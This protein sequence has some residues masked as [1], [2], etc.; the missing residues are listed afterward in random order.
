VNREPVLSADHG[1]DDPALTAL[2]AAAIVK[3]SAPAP[4]LRARPALGPPGPRFWLSF[5]IAKP[6]I[7]GLGTKSFAIMGNLN[8]AAPAGIPTPMC[9]RFHSARHRGSQ[10]EENKRANVHGDVIVP[11]IAT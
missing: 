9:H 4:H 2:R 3:S 8:R 1:G 10:L 6:F 7:P 11:D 5:M